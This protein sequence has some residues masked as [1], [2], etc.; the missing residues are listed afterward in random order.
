[1]P[2]QIIEA[3]ASDSSHTCESLGYVDIYDAVLDADYAFV[4]YKETPKDGGDW[5]LRIKSSQ[6]TGTVFEQDATRKNARSANSQ[7]KPYFTWGAGIEPSPGDARL[8]EYR[9]HHKDGKPSELEI[10]LQMRKADGSAGEA[11]TLRV[12]WPE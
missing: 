2:K 4:I 10:A 12:K 3:P 1:M 8:I 7:G 9:M 5:C 11:K 6:T